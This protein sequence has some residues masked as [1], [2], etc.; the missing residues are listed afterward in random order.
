MDTKEG[1]A[2]VD[3]V[4]KGSRVGQAACSQKHPSCTHHQLDMTS[5]KLDL[6]C[7]P[8][9]S[10]PYCELS[11]GCTGTAFLSELPLCCVGQSRIS[12]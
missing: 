7:D 12:G 5:T 11:C 10:Q 8:A 3:E 9:H 2:S 6:H 1:G 4:D